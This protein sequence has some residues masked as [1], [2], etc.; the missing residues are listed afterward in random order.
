MTNM[1]EMAVNN[2]QHDKSNSI[3]QVKPIWLINIKYIYI[4]RIYLA[5]ILHFL[6]PV[7]L[8]L[9]QAK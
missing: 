4:I 1:A 5:Y 7:N 2:L 9:E 6:E 8:W 3:L